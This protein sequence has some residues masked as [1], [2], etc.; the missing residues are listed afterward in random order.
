MQRI[1]IEFSDPEQARPG[2][3]RLTELV[4]AGELRIGDLEFVHSID[5]IASTVAADRVD[6]GLAGLDGAASGLLTR[7]ELDAVAADLPH[8]A[9]AAVLVYDGAVDTAVNVWTSDGARVKNLPP[10]S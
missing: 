3:G 8:R 2:F 6:P 10:S 9:T 7:H 4:N 1:V 5:G